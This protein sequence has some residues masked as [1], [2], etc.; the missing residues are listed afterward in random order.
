M[1][2]DW[3]FFLVDA[4]NAFNEGNRIAMLWMVRHLWPSGAQCCFKVY[5]HWATLIIWGA[6]GQVQ[7]LP[8]GQR[9][10]SLKVTQWPCWHMDSCCPP[11]RQVKK[12][13]SNMISQHWY[14]LMTP[15]PEGHLPPSESSLRDC[16]S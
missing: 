6:D 14:M 11:I 2:D 16:R 1:Q 8:A 9:R 10:V 7:G 4:R 5:Q 15:E 3:S 12:E 13:H